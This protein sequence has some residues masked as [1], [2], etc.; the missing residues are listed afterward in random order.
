MNDL[1]SINKAAQSLI[2]AALTKQPCNPVRTLIGNTE[3][4]KAYA[5]QNRVS[6]KRRQTGAK[7]I[8]VKV[9]LTSEAVQ[10]QL[11]VDQPDYGVLFDDMQLINGGTL[12]WKELM[13]PRVEAEIA[14]ILGQDIEG[15]SPNRAT[16]LSAIDH[17]RASL[18]VVGSRIKDWDIMI[19]DTIADNASASHFV[20]G[21]EKIALEQ[22]DLIQCSME[23]KKNQELVSTGTGE[24]CLGSPLHALHW[25]AMTMAQLGDPLKKGDIVL[26][27]ALGPM[28][29]LAPGDQIEA[30][31]SGLGSVSMHVGSA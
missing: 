15:V 11:G 28:T 1:E 22:I 4:Q 24:A 12:S 3:L 6:A 9:G 21:D 23:L 25:L 20:L 19:T 10:V 27:G 7:K 29:S 2:D 5:V 18:E 31:I 16:V 30:R 13:Q 8:G 14:F 26:S 17:C